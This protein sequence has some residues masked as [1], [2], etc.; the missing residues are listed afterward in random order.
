MWAVRV[1]GHRGVSELNLRSRPIEHR[2]IEEIRCRSGRRATILG[3]DTPRRAAAGRGSWSRVCDC[4]RQQ[5]IP[6]LRVSA[7]VVT[8]R[9]TPAGTDAAPGR[10]MGP[11]PTQTMRAKVGTALPPRVLTAPDAPSSLLPTIETRRNGSSGSRAERVAS[12]PPTVDP[13][14]IMPAQG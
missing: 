12:P 5:E 1:N 3:G 13:I 6:K 7:R 8:D 14:G 11:C 4:R 10:G 9:V 2:K